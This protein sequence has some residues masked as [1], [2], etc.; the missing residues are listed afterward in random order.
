MIRCPKCRGNSGETF[1]RA[2]L[3]DLEVSP[4]GTE[5]LGCHEYTD[6]NEADCTCGWCGKVRDMIDEDEEES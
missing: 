4:D 3:T 2:A 6:D 1:I 5:S